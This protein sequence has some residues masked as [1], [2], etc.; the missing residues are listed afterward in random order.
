MARHRRGGRER[1]TPPVPEPLEDLIARIRREREEAARQ[2]VAWQWAYRCEWIDQ[3]SGWVSGS[4]LVT[5]VTNSGTNYRGAAA[6]ARAVAQSALPSCI[7]HQ[8]G[9]GIELR[10]SCSRVG[11]P[12]GI[13][14][15]AAP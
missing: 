7:R 5:V 6:A 12:I 15:G 13:P 11:E 9:R 4:T 10:M 1:P 2:P 3:A 8:I 14:R